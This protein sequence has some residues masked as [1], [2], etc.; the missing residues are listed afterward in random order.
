VPRRS[1]NCGGGRFI[2]ELRLGEP[3]FCPDFHDL[4][5]HPSKHRKCGASLRRIHKRLTRSF[6]EAQCRRGVAYLEILALGDKDTYIAFTDEKQ[7]FAFEKHLKSASG[8]AFA[9]S[10]FEASVAGAIVGR[11][12]RLVVDSSSVAQAAENPPRD[13]YPAAT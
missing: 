7:A 12:M 3:L 6:A 9:K 10:A 13:L 8:R 5:V 4:R 2:H 11:A 1:L